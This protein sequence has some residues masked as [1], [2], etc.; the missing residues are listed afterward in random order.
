M[1]DYF[2]HGAFLLSK[3][4]DLNS[5]SIIVGI[6]PY[7]YLHNRRGQ[8]YNALYTA[9]NRKEC[10]PWQEFVAVVFDLESLRTG[11]NRSNSNYVV[12]DVL[13]GLFLLP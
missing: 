1:P 12:A 9:E 10:I 2:R 4:S 6:C 5:I 7:E 3:L 11:Q 8:T 13:S